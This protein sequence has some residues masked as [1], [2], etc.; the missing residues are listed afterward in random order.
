MQVDHKEVVT[1]AHSAFSLLTA[2][3]SHSTIRATLPGDR[4]YASQVACGAEIRTRCECGFGSTASR[5]KR[6]LDIQVAACIR[7]SSVIGEAAAVKGPY[8]L[9]LRG[10]Q[11]SR[12]PAN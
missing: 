5:D 12:L 6:E 8:L 10:T 11:Q 4:I 1:I 2:R 9:A 7:A 3:T